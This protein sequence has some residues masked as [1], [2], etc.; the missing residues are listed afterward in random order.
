MPRGGSRL[1]IDCLKSL[2]CFLCSAHLGG[3]GLNTPSGDPQATDVVVPLC[4]AVLSS[5]CSL[6]PIARAIQAKRVQ[7]PLE[8]QLREHFHFYNPRDK[9]P[10][11]FQVEL[12]FQ[13]CLHLAALG[14][15]NRAGGSGGSGSGSTDRTHGQRA[16]TGPFADGRLWGHQGITQY[17]AHQ[18]PP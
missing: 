18:H 5:S 12:R 9:V 3:K 16:T 1:D 7:Q 17:L 13:K 11:G 2:K 4:S 10:E 14:W 15:V 8:S 6:C